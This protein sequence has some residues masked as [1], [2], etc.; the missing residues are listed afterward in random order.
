MCHIINIWTVINVRN[1]NYLVKI[2]LWVE[3]HVTYVSYG[4]Q[5]TLKQVN[6]NIWSP[7]LGVTLRKVTH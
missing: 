2:K 7:V 5:F 1:K 6:F 4:T 3:I